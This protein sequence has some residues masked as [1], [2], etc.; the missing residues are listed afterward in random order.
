MLYCPCM[1][2]KN[3]HLARSKPAYD[4]N[5][6]LPTKELLSQL[7]DYVR[8]NS[9]PAAK[10][11]PAYVPFNAKKLLEAADILEQ[12]SK[13]SYG[14]FREFVKNTWVRDEVWWLASKMNL[15]N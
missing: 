7:R 12:L 14:T 5:E 1:S 2:N 13:V 3:R 10:A 4:D 9:T 8:N 6:S 11:S 15:K